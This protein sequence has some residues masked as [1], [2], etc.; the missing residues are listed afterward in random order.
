MNKNVQKAQAMRDKAY[1]KFRQTGTLKDWKN[2]KT[3]RNKVVSIIRREKEYY[4]DQK[5]DMFKYDSK[6]CGMN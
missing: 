1:R 4:Y 6:K 2:Y 5:F 3:G